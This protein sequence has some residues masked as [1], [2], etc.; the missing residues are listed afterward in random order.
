MQKLYDLERTGI[1]RT[2]DWALLE[3]EIQGPGPA[4]EADRIEIDLRRQ[5]LYLI[6]AQAVTGVFPVSSANGSL[7]QRRREARLC[8]DPGGP[9]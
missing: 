7:S 5:V 2:E 9:L 4:P 6:E 8:R 1:F 3:R